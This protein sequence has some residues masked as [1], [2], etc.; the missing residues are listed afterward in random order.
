MN[1]KKRRKKG[2]IVTIEL[3]PYIYE[4]GIVVDVTL[5]GYVTLQSGS[6]GWPL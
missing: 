1:T 4:Q 3:S 5:C 6:S 2:E